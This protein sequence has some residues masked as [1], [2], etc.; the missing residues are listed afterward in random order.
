MIQK[1]RYVEIP[2]RWTPLKYHAKQAA[3]FHSTTKFINL[4]CGRGSGKTELAR[5]KIVLSLMQ[6]KPWRKPIYFYALPTYNQAKRVAWKEL[7][8]LIPK[9]WIDPKNGG[10]ANIMDM[11]IKTIFGSELYVLGMDMPQR[12]EGAQYDGGV[13]DEACDQKPGSF[14]LSIKPAL[15]WRD[16]WV[17]RI[18]V[19]KRTGIG[20]REF[21]LACDFGNDP[22]N[23]DTETY[24]WPSSDILDPIKLEGYKKSMDPKDYNEQFNASW[25]QAGGLIF[26]TFKEH[27]HIKDSIC[28]YQPHLPLY[29]G[30]DFNVDPMCWVVCQIR[31]NHPICPG[32]KLLVALDEVFI[33]NTNTPESLNMLYKKYAFHKERVYFCGDAASHQRRT[34]ASISDYLHIVN[35]KPANWTDRKVLIP[36]KN[37]GLAD[38]FSVCNSVIQSAEGTVR[39]YV[40]SKCK[41][42]IDDL[43]YR[44]YKEGTSDPNDQDD[45]GHMTDAL[46]Y[47][48]YSQFPMRVGKPKSQSIAM[49]AF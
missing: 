19:P 2:P 13:V 31:E 41:R 11:H 15:T 40:H 14:D 36:N 43:N 21:K 35:F 47:L 26:Y 46:G 12:I 1:Q 3:A 30:M 33:R 17:W 39:F 7:M 27:I 24:S 10:H 34:S 49:Q 45:A 37:P 44:A 20:S 6:R 16:G 23:I 9:Y 8:D 48:M 4:P 22:A 28:Q 29:I 38:R 42:L 18:G 5:R 25:E 32:E